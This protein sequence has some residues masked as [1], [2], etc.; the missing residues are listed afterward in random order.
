MKPPVKP[1]ANKPPMQSPVKAPVQPPAK[2]TVVSP[3]PA[4]VPG[5]NAKPPPEKKREID[6]DLPLVSVVL[7]SPV[8][9]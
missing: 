4:T 8:S 3:K 6:D 2:M 5:S 7:A 1:T 9:F